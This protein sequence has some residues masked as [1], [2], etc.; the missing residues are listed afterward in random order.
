MFWGIKYYN[1]MLL[2]SGE[3]G[4]VQTEILMSKEP[5]VFTFREGWAFPRKIS[6]NGDECVMPPPDDYP[7]LPNAAMARK[8][9]I[10]SL[11]LFMT[12]VLLPLVL[13]GNNT[14]TTQPVD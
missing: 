13:P 2:Q 9:S 14:A 4:N 6:F 11:P 5:S 7:R 12:I 1:D 8:Q 10:L 3:E